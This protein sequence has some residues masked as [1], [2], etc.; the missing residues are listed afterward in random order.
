[1]ILNI[2]TDGVEGQYTEDTNESPTSNTLSRVTSLTRQE[3]MRS[4]EDP[5]KYRH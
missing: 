4:D 3:P 5:S 1:M 2:S